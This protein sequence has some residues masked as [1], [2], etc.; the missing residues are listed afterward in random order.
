MNYSEKIITDIELHDVEGIRQCFSNGVSPNDLYN[1]APLIYELVGEYTRTPR[2]KDCVQAFVDHGLQLED[3]LLLSVFLDDAPSLKALLAADPGLVSKTYTL[4]CAYTPL[5]EVNLLHIC[6]EFNHTSTAEILVRYGADIDV[7]AGVDEHGFGGQT[8]IFHT[9]NQNSNRSIDMLNFLLSKGSNL[10][11]HVKGLIWGYGYPWETLIPAVT[12]VSYAMMG[13]LPQ[14]HRD[15]S[16]ITNLVSL[17]LKV[18]YGIEYE[19]RNV[20]NAYLKKPL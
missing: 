15:E 19:P 18:A 11:H 2:F 17:L 1:N 10:M 4:P 13:L 5:F 8:P 20:P 12:P 3:K 7:R 6:A 14:M 9:V 16:T